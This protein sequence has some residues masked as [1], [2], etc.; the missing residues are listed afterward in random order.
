MILKPE[1]I[2][3]SLAGSW[4][5]FKGRAE[6]MHAFDVSI[7]GFWR[8]FGV[9][10]LL[11]LPY[12]VTV[13]AEKRIIDQEAAIPLDDFS[14][15]SFVFAKAI[16][17]ALDWAC[18]PIIVAL[19]ARPLGI[20]ARYVPYIVAR[21]WT[22]AIAIL[23]YMAPALLYIAGLIDAGTT[24]FLTLV[25]IGFVLRY[26][27]LVARIALHATIGMAIGLVALDT[28]LSFVIGAAVNRAIGM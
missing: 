8:S 7:T 10:L 18:F 4:E 13:I 20:S 12:A 26:R 25:A 1:E 9:I 17:F 27:Y 19:I 11:A 2:R 28:V 23:P 16:G 6:G 22:S 21:N 15:Q 24:A 14:Q 3:R 5:L